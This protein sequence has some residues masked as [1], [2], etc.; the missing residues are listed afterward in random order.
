MGRGGTLVESMPLDRK[1]GGSNSA[2]AA[3]PGTLRGKVLH[4]QLPVALRH[5]NSDIVSIAV[6]G[7]ASE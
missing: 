2:L 3:M 5:V 4:L 1:G 7:N 6:V